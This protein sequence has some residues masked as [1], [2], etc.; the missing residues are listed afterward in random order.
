MRTQ[1]IF[2]NSDVRTV[3]FLYMHPNL[4]IILAFINSF[5]HE[6]KIRFQITSIYRSM[7]ENAK[8][9]AKSKTHVEDRAFDFSIKNEHGWTKEKLEELTQ[10]INAEFS[11]IGAR[12]WTQNRTVL[13]SRPILVHKTKNG[14]MHAHVQVKP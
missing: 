7:E 13:I 9:E 6:N 10:E 8:V 5:C 11:D 3:D 14:A 1:R 2:L 4:L 12:V